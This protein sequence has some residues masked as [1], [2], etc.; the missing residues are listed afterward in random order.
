M[1]MIVGSVLGPGVDVL[2]PSSLLVSSGFDIVD[3]SW[4][5]WLP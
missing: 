5:R 4:C 1:V 2:L 3:F